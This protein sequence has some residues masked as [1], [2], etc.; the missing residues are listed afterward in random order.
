MTVPLI[1]TAVAGGDLALNHKKRS[2]RAQQEMHK[3]VLLFAS[4]N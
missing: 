2:A 1:G 3:A 4:K